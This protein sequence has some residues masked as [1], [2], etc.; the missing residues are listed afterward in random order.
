VLLVVSSWGPASAAAPCPE[1]SARIVLNEILP[2]P[3]GADAGLEWVELYNPSATTTYDLATCTFADG[4]GQADYTFTA[5]SLIA[6]QG[7]FAL[8]ASPATELTHGF[9]GDAMYGSGAGLSATSDGPNIVCNAVIIDKVDYSMTTGFPVPVPLAMEG[10][11][12]QLSATKL[13][14]TQNDLG[15]NWC[16]GTTLYFTAPLDRKNFGTPKAANVAC[17]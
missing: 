2:D 7:Y 11:T 5:G 16:F 8:S 6:P 12:L 9:V 15:A 3:E 4:A 17:P 14:A 10:Q 1:P 13:D